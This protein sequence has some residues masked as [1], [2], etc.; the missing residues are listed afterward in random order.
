MLAGAAVTLN[1]ANDK[2]DKNSVG[3]GN[4]NAGQVIMLSGEEFAERISDY[5]IGAKWR[6]QGKIPALVDFYADWCAPCKK[7]AP[8]MEE[9]AEEYKGRIHIY[10][11]DVD[12]NPDVANA[13]G[14]QSIPSLLFIPM[15]DEPQMAV[16]AYP[17]D[18]LKALIDMVLLNEE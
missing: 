2:D 18:K 9:L 11:V 16:G 10:K 8:I 5:T 12:E 15:D 14:I 3:A 17:K 1:A 6:Y 7:L 4:Q 13:F